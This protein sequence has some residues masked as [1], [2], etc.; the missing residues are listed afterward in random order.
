M[1][2][3][4]D[5]A[6]AVQ[7]AR[8]ARDAARDR[9]YA[10]Q[11]RDLELQRAVGR[12][13]RGDGAADPAQARALAALRGQE[14]ALAGHLDAVTAQRAA[15]AA[16][17]AALAEAQQR[18]D[19]VN[20]RSAELAR[21]AADLGGQLSPDI[22]AAERDAA[23]ARL[24]AVQRERAAVAQSGQEP[25]AQVVA[26]T[27][28]AADAEAQAAALDAD[29]QASRA[30]LARVREQID[31]AQVQ[32]P[33]LA[34]ASARA[35]ADLA[36]QRAELAELEA[37]VRGA[38][39]GLYG[40]QT[41]QQLIESWDDA[42]PILLL[43]LRLETRWKTAGDTPE[44]WVR[45]YPDDVE[46]CTH[47][48]V[49]TDAEVADGQAYW[50]RRQAATSDDERSA[51]W[52]ALS[53]RF[54]ANRA[55][56]VARET[57]PSNWDAAADDPQLALDFPPVSLT[58][59]DSWTEAPHSRVLPDRLV[60][61]GWRRGELVV[62]A[63]GAALDD[64]VVLGPAPLGDPGGGPSVSRNPGDQTL[65]LGPSFVWVRDFDD[66]VGRGLG[67]RL[68]LDAATARLGL[69]E[70]IVLGLKASSDKDDASA[71]LGEL[72]DDHHYARPGFALIPQGT[73][74]NNTG[75]NDTSYTRAGRSGSESAAEVGPPLFTPGQDRTRASDGQR[76]ADL[77]GIAYDPLLQVTGADL[78]D[79]ADAVAANRALYAG[80]LGYYL[81]HLLDEV[82]DEDALGTV[83]RH[84]A[85][86]VTGRGPLA[87][88]QVGP[89][90]YGILPTSA[91]GRWQPSRLPQG[92]G[93]AAP[94][95][96]DPFEA[97]LQGVLVRFDQAWSSLPAPVQVGAPG[98]GAAHLLDVL[99]LQPASAEL[100]QRVGYSYDTLRNIESFVSGGHELADVLKLLI[101]GMAARGLLE[102]LGY[103]PRRADGSAKPLPL[104]LQLIW[105]HYHTQ[106]DPLQLIDGQPLS[107]TAT[108]KP[109]DAASGKNF[110]DWL[111]DHSADAD[112]L[113]AQ[114]FG[115][116]PPPSSLL[117]LL[118]HFSVAMEAARGLHRFLGT[119]NVQ[120]PELVRSLAF[121]NVGAQPT[122]STWEV[123]R[124]PASSVV[125][126]VTSDRPLL[127]V[128]HSPQLV[129]D[130]GLD[131]AEQRDALTWL[132]G[133]STAR[134]E[135]VLIEHV[136][137][138]GYRLDA[139]QTSLFARRLQRQRRLDA[140][141]GE[142]RV[143]VY[144]GAYGYLEDARPAGA[145]RTPVDEETLPPELR[146]GTG[147]LT[148]EAGNG[149]YVH[150]ASLNHA[151]AAALLRSGYLTH[152][153]PA[154]PGTLAVNLSSDRVRRAQSL[155]DGFRNGQS[156]ETLLGAQFE[157]GLHDWT[158]R[159]AAPVILDQLKPLFRAAFPIER[160]QV[161]QAA[162]APVG[163]ATVT[164]DYQVVNGLALAQA[165]AF[166]WGI[167]SLTALSAA[168][169]AALQQEKDTIADSLDSLRDLFTAE[170]AYQLAL[171][172]FDRAAAVV[173]SVGSGTVPP[174]V[175]IVNTPRGTGISFT[176]RLAVQLSPAAAANPWPAV[177]ALTQRAL[178]DPALNQWLG[179]LLPDPAQVRCRVQALAAD[180]GHV[181]ADGG[182]T[183]ADLGLQPADVVS[184]VR[185][186]PQQ[187]SVAELEARVGYVFARAN[188]VPDG[189]VVRISFG[190]PGSAG[191]AS[192]A[193]V[194]PLAD[195]LRRLLGSATPLDARHFQ[196]ASADMPQPP[197]NLGRVD[198][199]ELTARVTARLD[200]V[201]ALF[202]NPA[203][204]PPVPP[205]ERVL[206]DA[207]APGASP[208]AVEALR[209][210]L[211]G[212]ADAGFVYA[213]PVSAVG[214]EA[215]QLQALGTQAD[216]VL[217]RHDALAAQTDAQLADLAA[218]T[219][220]ADSKT[221][222]LTDLVH[223][224][225][226]ADLL[227][228]PRFTFTDPASVTAADA[229]RD[230]L[231]D[232]A[233]AAGSLLPVDEW[234]HGAACV[235][236]L[237]HDFEM[238][239]TMAEA[240]LADP[241]PLAPLQL[242]FRTGDSWLGVEFPDAME[243][244]HDT[245]AV[246]QHL[247]QGFAPGGAQ[248]GLLIDEWT[249]TVPTRSE[250]TGLTFN[251][252]A[253]D[254]TPAQALLL[255]VTP[256]ETGSWNWDDL[257]ET[258]RDTFRRARLRAVEPDQ[259]GGLAGIGTLLPAVIAEFS[260]GRGSVSLDY[261][262]TWSAIRE[263]AVAHGLAG[264]GGGQ[265]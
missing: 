95:L 122:P 156:L 125:P 261:S 104:L 210:S 94:G 258:V 99:G 102:Q 181:L 117:Y 126:T 16:L 124:A 228:I 190:D 203:A 101:E 242:P 64:V 160:T 13:A 12:D 6:A 115:A 127:E 45:V 227:L 60:L 4:T 22:P 248:C 256:R 184:I 51:A 97:V 194:L 150:A 213:F 170:A 174:D 169:Q 158:T 18:L 175:Q 206:A 78:T 46:V 172:N 171:G 135:R 151:T 54:S 249:E 52:D 21:E 250:V 93:T 69:D 116:G 180:D 129:G 132:R 139:W 1:S 140:P 90:P 231:L 88:I 246:V 178:L 83:R 168:Q 63:V 66:A 19:A 255:A 34:G 62:S 234:L 71:L 253:P 188:A 81:D 199:A 191:G 157:R 50:T 219:A 30:A 112:A 218:S 244:V 121:R 243:V 195:R 59:A 108:I 48:K 233:R 209:A 237:V 8:A 252:D 187:S 220:P 197:D 207:R 77:V 53:Q 111:L 75:G 23:A 100:Y 57:K 224:W 105:R 73:A 86:L 26:L 11:L 87:A 149:G 35:D 214:T 196:S 182:L 56:W 107:E 167:A 76:L 154:Q 24:R 257:V 58:K 235:R 192:F 38:I 7:A 216:S 33:D 260:T 70:L 61:L 142:R 186:Q 200:A 212:I 145:A 103:Q 176:N 204:A 265:R 5:A 183:L 14:S 91:F 20:V 32:Q 153:T 98:D 230:G 40:R 254:S 143:G 79:F 208:A 68:G 262:F 27:A 205:L 10:L 225:L 36:G 80:T 55:A 223:G 148:E 236:P 259:L 2:A 110:I 159:P 130:S 222:Q 134:L 43:P 245:V 137:T 152:A 44:L 198:V 146:G 3:Y 72:I 128:L 39:G 189:A 15:L 221:G 131:L 161:P 123:F 147:E 211:L 29:G 31:A 239:R 89:Q 106:L 85:D 201:R 41:P 251:Y 74:T 25:R 173:Q 215:G 179:S 164:E 118:L 120:A 229:A 163:A 247:P 47:E 165:A 82:V 162:D 133:L 9:L 226:G 37:R 202:R 263:Q 138:L 113:E 42:L 177:P 84:F 185:S 119:L 241:L 217:A 67:F 264:S 92:E 49:L 28:Q 141:P 232:H 114:D 193:E 17:P 155:L 136:D 240:H 109:Y 65:D 96:A 166:P 144:L 238:V